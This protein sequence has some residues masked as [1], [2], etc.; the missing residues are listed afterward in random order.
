MADPDRLRRLLGGEETAWLLDRLRRRMVAGRPLSG[1]VTLSSATHDQR[2]AI[3]RLLGRRAGTGT[4]LSVSLDEVDTVLRRSGSAPDGLAD[5]TRLLIGTVP[6]RATEAAAWAAAFGPLDELV[7]RRPMLATWRA[8]LDSTGMV[9]RLASE[10][11][12]ASALITAVVDVLAELP[13]RGIALGRLAAE[14]TGDAH[15]LDDGR[16][17]ATLVLSA[18][19]ALRGSPPAGDGTAG[20]RR[21]SWAAVGVHRDELSSSVLC[22]GLPGDTETPTGRML[23]LAKETGEPCVLTLRQL[24]TAGL[25]VGAGVVSVCENPIV[26]ASAADELGPDCP[27]IVCVNGQ[28]SAAVWRLL[29]LLAE[30]RASFRYHG[31]FDWGGIRIGN[32]LRDRIP[33]MPWRFDASAYS[34]TTAEGGPLAG[35]PADATWDPD[36]RPTLERRGVRIEEEL[37]LPALLE[38][39]R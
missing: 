36:L 19:R 22:L 32:T 37:V 10:P 3:E 12:R 20:E 23:A 18:A 31:D 35:R 38:D 39:L 15:S 17:L 13:S 7:A 25:G 4:S 24:N 8:W 5:A 6:D 9:R 26:L 29:D 21:T 14:T 2:R 28:P 16:P 33:W 34:T 30:D 11:E 1:V 27:P